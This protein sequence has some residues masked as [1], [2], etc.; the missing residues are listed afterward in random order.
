LE[1]LSLPLDAGEARFGLLGLEAERAHA[2]LVE[3]AAVA[4][5]DVDALRPGREGL[6]GPSV[7]GVD[8][9]RDPVLQAVRPGSSR[10]SCA[11]RPSSAA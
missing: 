1:A 8:R 5:D 6:L 9:D 11:R 7:E 2:S 10:L 4:A 3:H